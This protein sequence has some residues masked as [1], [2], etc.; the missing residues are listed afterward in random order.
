MHISPNRDV[1]FYGKAGCESS[2][3][4]N[5]GTKYQA[6]FTQQDKNLISPVCDN[7]IASIAYSSQK[8]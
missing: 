2:L 7:V 5:A 6:L 3:L 8:P 4:S 1:H